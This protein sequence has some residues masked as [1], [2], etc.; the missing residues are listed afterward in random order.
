MLI[1]DRPWDRAAVEAGLPALKQ[2]SVRDLHLAWGR[3]DLRAHGT[4]DVDAQGFAAGRLDIAATNW[5]DMIDV[6]EQG[7]MIGA[8]MAGTLRVGLGL[9][10][11]MAGNR[12]S[13][14]IP[15]AFADGQT[16]LGP[17]PIGPA[18]RLATR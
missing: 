1:F 4:L 17:I 14:E 10:A 3:L 5:R 11:Q 15:L 7:G 18:P 13:I 2:V 6:A 12:E 9:L 16:R 8:N